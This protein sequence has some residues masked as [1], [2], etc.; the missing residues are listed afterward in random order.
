MPE[1]DPWALLV[2]IPTMPFGGAGCEIRLFSLISVLPAPNSNHMAWHLRGAEALVILGSG[3]QPVC[4]T[5]CH[6][7][8]QMQIEHP[9]SVHTRNLA[10][11]LMCF[12]LER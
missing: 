3:T 6:P 8:P 2:A 7:K 11:F 4:C 9:T 5:T 12:K 1:A 10:E